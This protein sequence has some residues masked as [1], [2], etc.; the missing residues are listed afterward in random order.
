MT[1]QCGYSSLA[2]NQSLTRTHG[3]DTRNATQSEAG[4]VKTSGR[5]PDEHD[6]EQLLS[7]MRVVVTSEPFALAACVKGMH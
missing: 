2:G 4:Y 1:V 3:R 7:T 5:G 6:R